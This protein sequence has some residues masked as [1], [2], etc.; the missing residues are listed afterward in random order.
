[1]KC[2]NGS[3][4]VLTRG[5]WAQLAKVINCPCSDGKR[6][7]AVITGMADT[8]FS[9]PARVSVR[10]KTVT[11]Y[12]TCEESNPYM[13]RV[14]GYEFHA[15]GKNA[16][17]LPEWPAHVEYPAKSSPAYSGSLSPWALSFADVRDNYAE[18]LSGV[19]LMPLYSGGQVL[20][21]LPYRSEA[22]AALYACKD[23]YLGEID[24]VLNRPNNVCLMMRN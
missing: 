23:V 15:A 22:R 16:G 10:G 21:N 11:G 19:D 7:T 14:G 4:S 6:R 12:L 18:E 3:E 20:L 13:G 24:A 17:A 5:P 8:Y 9:I 2:D 1:M